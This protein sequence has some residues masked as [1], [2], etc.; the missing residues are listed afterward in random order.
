MDRRA[1]RGDRLRRVTFAAST[2]P[3]R[4]MPQTATFRQNEFDNF[5]V[6]GNIARTT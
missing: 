1:S 4:S 2:G 6:F 5:Y 3:N